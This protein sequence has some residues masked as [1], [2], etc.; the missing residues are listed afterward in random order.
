M[1]TLVA[2]AKGLERQADNMSRRKMQE[3]EGGWAMG[4]S[5]VVCS[6]YSN[7]SAITLITVSKIRYQSKRKMRFT[8]YITLF[9]ISS[10]F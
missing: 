6:E 4:R 8:K 7:I 3:L 2:K 10:F 5:I 9:F 1:V